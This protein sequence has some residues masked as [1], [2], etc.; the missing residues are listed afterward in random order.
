MRCHAENTLGN[1]KSWWIC[2]G[3]IWYRALYNHCSN[4]NK[5]TSQPALEYTSHFMNV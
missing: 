1:L 3:Y 4:F 5:P 2:N